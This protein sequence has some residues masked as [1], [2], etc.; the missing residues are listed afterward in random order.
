MSKRTE[1]KVMLAAVDRLAMEMKKKLRQ[2][3]NEGYSGGLVPINRY[4]V[5]KKLQEHAER[6]TG[7]CPHCFVS[8]GEHDAEGEAR[9]AVDVCNLAMMLWV[10]DS[11]P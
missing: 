8:D 1:L 9:Q 3:A 11:R 2:K 7:V 6:L 10:V 4:E 5:A